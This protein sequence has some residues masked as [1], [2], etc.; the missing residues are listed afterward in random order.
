MDS[1]P[2]SE[3]TPAWIA[4]LQIDES[5]VYYLLPYTEAFNSLLQSFGHVILNLSFI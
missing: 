5:V 2:I 1:P 3:I 4:A